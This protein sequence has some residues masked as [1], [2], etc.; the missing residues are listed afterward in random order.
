MELQLLMG[1]GIACM[2][3]GGDGVVVWEGAWEEER[4]VLEEA[5]QRGVM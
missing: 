1:E 5:G 3:D 4:R 2:T